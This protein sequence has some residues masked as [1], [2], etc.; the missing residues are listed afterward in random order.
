MRL[1]RASGSNS[2]A[3]SSW[4]LGGLPPELRGD[5]LT[6]LDLVPRSSSNGNA[7]SL[8]ERRRALFDEG[9]HYA[10]AERSQ[11]IGVENVL[12][13][14]DEVFHWLMPLPHLHG[15][16]PSPVT[17]QSSSFIRNTSLA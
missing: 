2:H 4:P 9:S 6:T 13:R 12:E 14:V 8:E 16:G 17:Q 11:I 1:V 7:A 5:R 3:V 10:P 15:F